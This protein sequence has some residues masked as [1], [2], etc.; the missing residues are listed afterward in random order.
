M[1]KLYMLTIATPQI[2]ALSKFYLWIFLVEKNKNHHGHSTII[3]T[4]ITEW[5]R[6]KIG[7]ECR[8]SVPDYTNNIVQA[9]HQ[10]D[11]KRSTR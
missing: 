5:D 9:E 10:L 2:G 6:L 7:R 3:N 8:L 11:C 1:T 4:E